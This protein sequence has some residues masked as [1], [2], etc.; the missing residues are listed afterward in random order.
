MIPASMVGLSLSIPV[1]STSILIT[2][3]KPFNPASESV[4][5]VPLPKS[6]KVEPEG[7]INFTLYESV[8]NESNKYFPFTSVVTSSNNVTPSDLYN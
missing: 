5:G 8:N 6:V 3:E 4:A 7:S 1:F 2:P